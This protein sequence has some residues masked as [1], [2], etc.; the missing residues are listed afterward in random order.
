MRTPFSLSALLFSRTQAITKSFL[1]AIAAAAFFLTSNLALPQPANAFPFYAQQNYDSPREATG[2]I[3]CANCHLA[4]KP[5][6]V[7][8][9]QA[10]LPDTVFGAVVKIPYEDGLQQ[11]QPDGSKGP[12]NVG[13]VVILPEGFKIAPEDRIPEEMKEETAGVYFQN[14]SDEQ[15]NI[16]LVGPVPG[17]QNREIVFPVLSPDPSTDKDIHFGKY[18]IHVGANRG[19]GQVYPTGD[20]TNNTVYTASV[21]GTVAA[22]EASGSGY[23]VIIQPEEGDAVVETIPPGP[24]LIVA[25]GD[26]V[27]ADAPLTDDPNVGGFGQTDRE[28][29]LQSAGRVGWLIAFFAAITLSQ[30]L[31]VLKKKQIER[32]QAAEMDF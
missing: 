11:V 5:T 25:E 22:I 24:S 23:T 7:E 8:I 12:L 29:V 26:T 32:V 14:Y 27:V 31:L 17:D 20:K 1:V 9:P 19:R 2:R 21:S 4:A 13:A 15:D 10:V 16:I 3:V 6:E 28:I 30:T 18:P